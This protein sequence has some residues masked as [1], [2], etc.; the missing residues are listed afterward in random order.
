MSAALQETDDVRLADTD[1]AGI[2]VA[3][4]SLAAPCIRSRPP[5]TRCA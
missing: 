5:R 4:L 3:V 1:A 2:E